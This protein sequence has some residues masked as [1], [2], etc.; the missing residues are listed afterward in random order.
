[1]HSHKF[2]H[3]AL[4]LLMLCIVA[5]VLL[6]GVAM[7]GMQLTATAALAALAVSAVLFG[8]MAFLHDALRA[9][10]WNAGHRLHR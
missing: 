5:A 6:A 4:A 3:L 1:M 9:A 8:V 10:R 2:Y 7:Y